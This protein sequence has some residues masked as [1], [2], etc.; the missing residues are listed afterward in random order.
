MNETQLIQAAIMFIAV[1]VSLSIHEASHALAAKLQGDDTAQ[2]E[3]RLTLNPLAHIDP[4]GTVFLPLMLM[5]LGGVM[6]GWA[7][8]VPV[9]LRKLRS[10][11]WGHVFVAAAGPISNLL[12]CAIS[13]FILS[14]YHS[15]VPL[16]PQNK[17]DIFTAACL[18]LALINA[19]LAVFNLIPLA[20]LDG[21]TVF[22]AFLPGKLRYLYDQFVVPYGMIILLVLVA[23]GSLR[24]ISLL[25]YKYINLISSLV[26]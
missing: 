6:F 25:A 19:F 23:T 22:A 9:N 24:W 17:G 14:S 16:T 3:G 12:L 5:F 15:E 11:K 26:F 1:I 20:P 13:L 10:P 21:S 8:P 18:S 7:K 2:R 4:V